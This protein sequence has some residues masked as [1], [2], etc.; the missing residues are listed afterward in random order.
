MTI[1]IGHTTVEQSTSS[2]YTEEWMLGEAEANA[3]IA[4]GDIV[5]FDNLEDFLADLDSE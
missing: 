5:Q 2:I 4:A 3:Q 1:L